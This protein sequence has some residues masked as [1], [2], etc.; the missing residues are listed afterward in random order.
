MN[1]RIRTMRGW[2]LVS[3]L[4]LMVSGCGGREVMVDS[5]D[6]RS[7]AGAPASAG[8]GNPPMSDPRR[9]EPPVEVAAPQVSGGA[10]GSGGSA[11][12]PASSSTGSGG[13]MSGGAFATASG[14]SGTAPWLTAG[15]AGYSAGQGGG[16]SDGS[17]GATVVT[18]GNGRSLLL[19]SS[20]EKEPTAIATYDGNVYVADFGSFNNDGAVFGL[21]KS[22]AQLFRVEQL[23]GP[24]G[25][26]ADAGGVYWAVA[27]NLT[28]ANLDGSNPTT[29]T[30]GFVNDPITIGPNGLYGTGMT[31]GVVSIG[32]NG[33]ALVS[34][35]SEPPASFASYG[36]AADANNVYWSTFS[37]P[38]SIHSAPAVPGD[39]PATP[40]VLAT[41]TG[42]GGNIAIDAHSVY[43]V[44]GGTVLKVPLGGGATSVLATAPAPG[45][46]SG[47]AV[48]G[49]SVY[50]SAAHSIMKVSV[51]GGTPEELASGLDTPSTL[52]LD[53][54][55]VYFATVGNPD[56]KEGAIYKL[57]PK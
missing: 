17:G 7:A 40:T 31:F 10:F 21:D 9:T 30:D 25:I 44:A 22:G 20:A 16:S 5:S 52:A 43:W 53:D 41:S 28:H 47:I 46:M 18:V 36:L 37:N 19:L 50:W 23:Q 57:T 13:S 35:A 39:T 54:T 55:S 42:P 2:V 38:M 11:A 1:V 29:L 26:A 3:L 48:D 34:V 27:N 15:F 8:Q 4:A 45:F 6:P 49:T 32:L 33:G 24:G 51:D 12:I 14:G 56:R